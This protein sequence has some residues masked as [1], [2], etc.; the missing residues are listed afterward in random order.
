M[1]TKNKIADKLP[2]FQRFMLCYCLVYHNHPHMFDA[3]LNGISYQFIKLVFFLGK[4][5]K[6]TCW[7][8]KGGTEAATCRR[9]KI[10]Y[11]YFSYH[12]C[13]F[14]CCVFFL[15]CSTNCQLNRLS[16]ITIQVIKIV[17]CAVR[18]SFS[19]LQKNLMP[20]YL[21]QCESVCCWLVLM[22]FFRPFVCYDSTADVIIA[23]NSNR[24]F[25]HLW[26]HYFYYRHL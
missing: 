15:L 1:L 20:F 10:F 9:R 19:H 21:L 2:S 3:G 13:Y 8:S 11:R 7:W 18:C 24:H 16:S 5:I 23:I 17:K 26:F 14:C 22:N 6:G 25:R 4:V 12:C